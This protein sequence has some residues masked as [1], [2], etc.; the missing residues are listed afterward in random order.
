MRDAF[1][2]DGRQCPFYPQTVIF[3]WGLWGQGDVPA[4]PFSFLTRANVF[5][6]AKRV[7]S[8][9]VVSL[10]GRDVLSRV[11]ILY[12]PPQ[13]VMP[14][15]SSLGLCS[16]SCPSGDPGFSQ[17]TCIHSI[18]GLRTGEI[19]DSCTGSDLCAGQ[20]RAEWTCVWLVSEAENPGKSQHQVERG[21]IL[22]PGWN[23]K[24]LHR[25]WPRCVDST[26]HLKNASMEGAL[27]TCSPNVAS[28]LRRAGVLAGQK[29]PPGIISY[30]G[31]AGL[32]WGVLH[33]S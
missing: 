30:W 16:S 13:T 10:V 11:C 25:L 27:A 31:G 28:P 4:L 5:G 12:C 7:P 18:P 14:S 29:V 8:T 1:Q 20:E 33:T 9:R 6:M 17:P 15:P 23:G 19:R 32:C 24:L 22:G 21:I 2:K 26:H 3:E